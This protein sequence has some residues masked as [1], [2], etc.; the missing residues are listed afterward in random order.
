MLPK[1]SRFFSASPIRPSFIPPVCWALAVG[2]VL[3]FFLFPFEAWA[4]EAAADGESTAAAGLAEPRHGLVLIDWIIIGLYAAAVVVMGWWFGRKQES[5]KEY[6]VGS[7]KMNP[8][9]IGVSLFATLLSTISY[10]A[11]P[12]E[13]LGKGPAYM[14]FM[15]AYP[16]IFLIVGYWLLPTYMRNK[17]VS[18]YELLEINLGPSVRALG[19]VL[20]LCLRL[21][22]MSLLVSVT[23]KA[24]V[25]MAGL[26]D[27]WIPWVAAITGLIAITYTSL[28]GLRAVVITDLL[29]T[30]LLYGGAVLVLVTITV[31][32]GG[33]SWFPTEWSP[34]WD[35]QPIFSLDP[36]TRVTVFGSILSFLIWN[37]AT[38][39]GDQVSVQR[40]MATENA[41]AARS[42]VLTNVIVGLIINITLGLAGLA[43]LGYFQANP[44]QLANGLTLA[45]DADKVFPHYIAYHLPPII[46]GLVVSGLFAAAMSS[47]DSGVN[48][49]TAVVMTD[50]LDRLGLRPKNERTHVIFARILAFVIG[51]VVVVGSLSVDKVPGNIIAVTNKTAN[52]LTV[53]IFCLFFFA[54]F[55]RRASSL[56]AW[57]G[58]IAGVTVAVLIA[59]S[60]YFR[61]FYETVFGITTAADEDPVSFQWMAPLSLAAN[62]GVG[63]LF[64]F[65]FPKK[66]K[67][68]PTPTPAS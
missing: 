4:Q 10:L 15:L 59:F 5:T 65:I 8:I 3:A 57:L 61:P 21:V 37:V 2:T 1:N 23:S 18:A 16:F 32:M 43:L 14:S 58:A 31:K 51:A 6:F 24:I 64:C 30:I 54:L 44:A 47:V 56:A 60:S 19:V 11:F 17:V 25:V 53:P 62:I 29:Q 34:H 40:F 45:N 50:V 22:W 46:S 7:G 33:F 68:A 35:S 48:S 39:G 67:P 28:G 66:N 12:G 9:L 55:V 42:A 52:L 38:A 26:E 20:F 49:I 13:T 36:T 63:L 27:S 41:K